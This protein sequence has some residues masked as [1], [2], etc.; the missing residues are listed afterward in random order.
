VG[1]YLGIA[2]KAGQVAAGD[3]ATE[4][5]L[6]AGRAYLLVLAQDISAAAAKELLYMAQKQ[7][8]PLLWWPDKISLGLLVGKSQRGALAVLDPGFTAAILKL[9]EEGNHTI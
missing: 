9:C 3:L 8:V 1:N 5:A 6:K 7:R 2:R 4:Q